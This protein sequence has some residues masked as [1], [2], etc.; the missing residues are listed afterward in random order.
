[1]SHREVRCFHGTMTVLFPLH[2]I[3]ENITNGTNLP[4]VWWRGLEGLLSLRLRCLEVIIRTTDNAETTCT[5]SYLVESLP[6]PCATPTRIAA[7]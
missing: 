3:K 6:A 4:V 2:D 5:K 1:M 7:G